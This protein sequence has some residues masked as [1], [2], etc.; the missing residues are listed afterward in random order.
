MS[1]VTCCCR[2]NMDSSAHVLINGR[3]DDVTG[4]RTWLVVC[5][6]VRVA[7]VTGTVSAESPESRRQCEC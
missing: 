2:S 1:K 4:A 7:A 6:V 3:V 5:L